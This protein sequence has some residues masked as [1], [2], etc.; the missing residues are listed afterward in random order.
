MK[1][2]CI[3]IKGSGMSTLAQIL[4]DLGHEVSGYDDAREE[5][6]TEIGLRKR[7]IPIFYD[8]THS[9]DPD[10]I[11]T[12]SKAFSMTHKELVR[13]K[14]LGL[15]LREY[16]DLL[17]DL[18]REFET[19]S[20]C[21]THGKTTTSLLLSHILTSEIGCNY[22]V[23]D[24]SGYANKE[25][26]LFILE[27]CEYKRHF[28]SYDPTNVIVTNI[29]LEHTECYD[30]IEDIIHTFQEFVNKASGVVVLCGDDENVRKL[31][32]EHAKEVI[33]Y[34]FDEGND[35]VAKNVVLTSRGSAFD[36]YRNGSFYG[37][38]DTPLYGRHMVLNA[39]A[40]IAISNY[41]HISFED[42]HKS[43]E[44]FQ[45]AKRRFKEEKVKDNILIDDYAHHPT[46]IRVTLE[47]ARQK[48]P[49]KKLIA[50]FLPNTYSRTQALLN[51]F[52]DVLNLADVTYVMDIECNREQASDYQNVSSD[53]ILEKLD[54]GYKLSVDTVD[55][56]LQY[57]D[58]VLCFMSCANI[59]KI[60][61]VYKKRIGK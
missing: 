55:Q 51:D 59:Q 39:L 23:G 18:T 11:V 24:G 15:K 35:L 14:E 22:F 20:V 32:A 19:T 46:E 37:H 2:Y 61:E 4:H 57:H 60:E 44:K 29:E 56:L 1:Y 13:V 28:L 10:T 27:S 30:G 47:S 17:G 26:K 43:I 34:G 54:Q 42:I 12:Y 3:G 6:Y 49:D 7:N 48:Y 31:K 50:I 8:G 16:N 21:G 25:N 41:Y 9:L 52:I 40:T 36:V 45:G 33:Y 58:S 5:K 53:M 38:F